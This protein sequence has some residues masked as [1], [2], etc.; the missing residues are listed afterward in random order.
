MVHGSTLGSVD[1]C[2]MFR[3]IFEDR[4]NVQTENLETCLNYLSPITL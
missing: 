2:K 1:L 3:Q 4:E